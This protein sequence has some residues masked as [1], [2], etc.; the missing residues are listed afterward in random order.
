MSCCE[1]QSLTF[2]SLFKVFMT[3]MT[4]VIPPLAFRSGRAP[5]SPL[6]LVPLSPRPASYVCELSLCVRRCAG[7]FI[8]IYNQLSCSPPGNPLRPGDLSTIT[9]LCEDVR[10][11]TAS[12][13]RGKYVT[14][15]PGASRVG[16]TG[17][18]C[19][20]A[21]SIWPCELRI[22]FKGL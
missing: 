19:P 20:V 3:F 8:Y 1:S 21:C 5:P 4:L 14:Y 18:I 22:I 16:A 9:Q 13:A 2:Q 12:T 11:R 10:L 7:H 17:Q 6:C 15:I